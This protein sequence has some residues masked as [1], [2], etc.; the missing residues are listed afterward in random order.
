MHHFCPGG[1]ENPLG[2]PCLCRSLLLSL[3]LSPTRFITVYFPNWRTGM[4]LRA[5]SAGTPA[6]APTF[7]RSQTH[8]TQRFPPPHH[9]VIN[10]ATA[11]AIAAVIDERSSSSPASLF[12][13]A[14]RV[15]WCV[16]ASQSSSISL[17]G[18]EPRLS[19]QVPRSGTAGS[20]G[21][22]SC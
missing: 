17:Y 2:R 11:A 8:Q 7:S 13:V 3:P 20:S 19:L 12:A 16:S 22:G 15:K 9:P 5:C 21:S 14:R 10:S 18:A 6:S 1:V 4:G